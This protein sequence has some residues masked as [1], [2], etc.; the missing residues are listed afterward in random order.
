MNSTHMPGAIAGGIVETLHGNSACAYVHV[1]CH[2]YIFLMQGCIQRWYDAIW[3]SWRSESFCSSNSCCINNS[4]LHYGRIGYSSGTSRSLI[5]S[6]INP[7]LDFELSRWLNLNKTQLKEIDFERLRKRELC[8][9]VAYTSKRDPVDKELQAW[10]SAPSA[11]LQ[12]ASI[13]NIRDFKRKCGTA[14]KKRQH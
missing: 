14:S 2:Y 6:H 3:E 1:E 7:T 5:S 4:D 9:P 13:A 8:P 11:D 10:Y 12:H